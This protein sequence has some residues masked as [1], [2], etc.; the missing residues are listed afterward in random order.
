MSPRVV[1]DGKVRRKRPINKKFEATHY[2][3][4]IVTSEVK[5][6]EGEHGVLAAMINCGGIVLQAKKSGK[7]PILSVAWHAFPVHILTFEKGRRTGPYGPTYN[8]Y[9]A[10]R[11]GWNNDSKRRKEYQGKFREGLEKDGR[12]HMGTVKGMPPKAIIKLMVEHIQKKRP[13]AAITATFIPGH[14]RPGGY[15]PISAA[16]AKAGE[17]D[18]ELI[19]ILG[20]LKDEGTIQNVRRRCTKA[21]KSVGSQDMHILPSGRI[22]RT[23]LNPRRKD[24][25]EETGGGK[26]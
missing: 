1:I 26:R 2:G 17:A 18:V 22:Y 12:V 23:I 16:Q 20:E 11:D 24:E 10:F 9:L 15:L 3:V 25:G 21:S 5:V 14:M 4:P 19:R 13:G 6:L 7:K 8:E